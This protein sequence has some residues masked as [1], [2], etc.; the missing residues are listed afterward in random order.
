[1]TKEECLNMFAHKEPCRPMNSTS[2]VK[3][4]TALK[5]MESYAEQQVKNLNTP[6]VSKIPDYTEV[7]NIVDMLCASKKISNDSKVDVF[8]ALTKL[9]SEGKCTMGSLPEDVY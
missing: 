7:W 8:K 6:N 1:M 4:E 5:A 3:Y 2:A 9:E